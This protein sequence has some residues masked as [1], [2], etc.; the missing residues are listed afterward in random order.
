MSDAPSAPPEAVEAALQ[1]LGVSR[2]TMA[3]LEAFV[4][5]LGLW[6]RRIHLV[7]PAE[8]ASLW[9]RHVLDSAQLLPLLPEGCRSLVDLGSGGGFP[10]LVLAILGVPEVHLVE[11]DLRKAAFLRE[12]AR[13]TGSS[14]VHV[15]ACRIEALAPFPVDAVTARALAPLPRLL[16]LAAPWLALGATGIFPKGRGVAA[17]LTEAARSWTMT[18]ERLPSATAADG[19]ILRIREARRVH[20][21]TA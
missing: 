11:A 2:E 1:A 8:L 21:A 4:A 16:T 12:A 9:P 3:R 17:E 19:C 6:Q 15:H 7:A 13:I 10:G 20:P 14:G 18:V 5:L